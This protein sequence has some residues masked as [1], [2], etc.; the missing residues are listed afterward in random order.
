MAHIK[1]LGGTGYG[2]AAVAAEAVRRG[3]TVTSY[4]RREPDAPID[5]VKYVTGSLLDE[6]LLADSVSD[7]DVVF[8][9]LS[10]RGDM[11]GKTEEIVDQ[12]IALADKQGARL[13][14]LGGVSSVLVSEGGERLFDVHPPAPEI[15]DEVQTGLTLLDKLQAAPESLDWFYVSPALSFGAWAPAPETGSYRIN[16]GVLLTDDKGESNISAADLAI[17]VLDE[18]ETPKYVRRRFH[19]AH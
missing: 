17:A 5:A 4:S 1:V 11:A 19:V 14:V 6:S 15:L 13:G 3:H 7:A 16:D 9:S 2:G 10:P 8:Y 12:L 18:V